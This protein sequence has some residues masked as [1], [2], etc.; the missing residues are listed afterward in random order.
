MTYLN[1]PSDRY[2]RDVLN[3][4]SPSAHRRKVSEQVPAASGL[5]VEDAQTGWVGAIVRVEK[6]GGVHVV[7]LED[8]N[9]RLKSFELGPGFLIDGRPVALVPAGRAGGPAEHAPKRTASGSVAVN[10]AKARVARGSRLWVEGRHDAELIEK[11]W[12]DD[13]RIEGIVVEPL[14]GLDVLP[15]RLSEFAPT[16][17]RKVGVLADHLIAGTKETR[18]VDGLAG[19]Y[20]G[21]VLVLGHP[22]IDIWA[23]VKPE[24]VGIAAW[25]D[26]PKGEPWKEG[27]L[28]RLGWPHRTPADVRAGWQR[29]LGCVSSYADVEATLSGRVEELIDFVTVD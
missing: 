5:V 2:G 7:T 10:D 21:N 25:P 9:D 4:S 16:S 12:G 13:L 27:T 20:A 23:A 15:E 14:G 8:R 29:I 18:L 1:S 22:Y 19:R 24:K 17:G 26:V 6:M 3:S 28:A 11:V